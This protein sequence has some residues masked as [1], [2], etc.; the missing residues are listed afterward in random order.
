[1]QYDVGL[2]FISLCNKERLSEVM[3]EVLK[4]YTTDILEL[5]LSNE[6]LDSIFTISKSKKIENKEYGKYINRVIL[7]FSNKIIS[8]MEPNETEER[9]SEILL[10][11]RDRDEIKHIIKFYDYYVSQTYA[12]YYKEIYELE[13]KL[14]EVLS[15]IFNVS[16]PDDLYETLKSHEISINKN[17]KGISRNDIEK[18]FENEFFY[19]DFSGYQDINQIKEVKQ[20][21]LLEYI[22]KAVSF[23]TLQ[24]EL[25]KLGVK[26]EYFVDFIESIKEIL[27]PIDTMRN[28]IMH[29]RKSSPKIIG[30]YEKA[31]EELSEKINNFWENLED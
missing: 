12:I 6:E 14:R 3:R 19:L 5:D 8:A 13:N 17:Y 28:H 15:Y 29:S 11:L 22:K 16:Y 4:E 1:M 30:S 27:N 21:D 10:T 24:K 7:D 26:K 25:N 9:I 18:N 31:K 2:Q 23:D 20:L